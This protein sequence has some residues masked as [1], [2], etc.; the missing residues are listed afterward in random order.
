MKNYFY[1]G[2]FN[3]ILT[4]LNSLLQISAPKNFEVFSVSNRNQ[5]NL[6][7]EYEIVN[8]DNEIAKHIWI[9]LRRN[10]SIGT[11]QIYKSFL[12]N[13]DEKFVL[14][15]LLKIANNKELSK[16][17]YIQIEK[18][19]QKID[20]EKNRILSYLRYNAQLNNSTTLYI[21][22][23]YK[24][25][26]LLTKTIRQLYAHHEEWQIVNSY[27]NHCIQFNDNK[28]TSKKV[29]PREKEMS[30]SIEMNALKLA[31]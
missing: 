12:A 3:G 30:S 20:R 11:D 25:E 13:E 18:N 31:V 8:T 19:A 1:D 29:N 15:L 24:V 26:F 17:E 27:Q 7:D 10:S 23:K 22:S 14:S 16:K 21:Q 9:L 5:A 28:F 2:T 4:L 6:F